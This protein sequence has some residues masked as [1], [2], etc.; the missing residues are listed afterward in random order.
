MHGFI[1]RNEDKLLGKNVDI[2]PAGPTSNGIRSF[3][4]KSRVKMGTEK[5][6]TRVERC[7]VSRYPTQEKNNI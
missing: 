1:D 3:S 2:L 7:I 6:E 5:V 4:C